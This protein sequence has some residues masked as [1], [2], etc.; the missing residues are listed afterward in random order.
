MNFI[1]DKINKIILI[2]ILCFTFSCA[3]VNK[4]RNPASDKINQDLRS[5]IEE[6]SEVVQ[7]NVTTTEQCHEGLTYY[8]NKLFQMTS[9]DVKWD[10][11]DD[12]IIE[13]LIKASFESRLIIKEKLKKLTLKSEMDHKCLDAVKNSFRALRYVEDYLIEIKAFNTENIINIKSKKY[14][15]LTG[16]GSYFLKNSQ[17]VFNSYHDLK[18]GDV[19]LSRGN[20]YSSA[21]IARIGNNDMQFSHLSFV[22][23]DENGKAW[24]TEAHIEIGSVVAPIETHIEQGNS[25]SVV[26][27]YK[28]QELAHQ[29]SKYMFMKVQKQQM[30]KKN[31]QYDFAMNYKDDERIFCSETIHAGFKAVSNG[32]IDVPRYKTKFNKGLTGFLQVLGIE[33]NEDNFESFDTFAPG[34]IQF[35]PDFEMVAEWRNPNKMSDSR[36]KDMILTKMFDWMENLNYKLDPKFNTS[37]MSRAS[38]LLRRTPLIKEFFKDKFPINMSS[39]Q[40][41]L[42]IVLDK[43]GDTL[44][45]KIEANQKLMKRPMAPI[46]MFKLLDKYREVDYLIWKKRKADRPEFHKLF[47]P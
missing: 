18:S 19:I 24:T 34:D 23:I 25:R 13:R 21:A 46:E 41:R 10:I 47:H 7:E 36:V 39:A 16:E 17:F 31:I 8:Y 3:N 5:M 43:V 11:L 37:V 4:W 2:I 30:N 38:W 14:I 6:L 28:N 20:A 29:A 12:E 40:L 26:F 35:D 27:R 44:K 45:A 32:E 15:N 33:I 9:E 22:Y 1:N 42:F